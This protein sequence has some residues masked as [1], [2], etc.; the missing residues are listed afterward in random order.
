MELCAIHH[1]SI[2]ASLQ[3]R[4]LTLGNRAEGKPHTGESAAQQVLLSM[5]YGRFGIRAMHEPMCPLCELGNQSLADEWHAA[6]V[7]EVE[8]RHAPR[9]SQQGAVR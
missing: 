2:R 6:A 8:R 4:G 1:A 7:E 3:G 5:A 9:D